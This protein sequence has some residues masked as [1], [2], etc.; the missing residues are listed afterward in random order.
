M[1]VKPRGG[2]GHRP[3][4]EGMD[5]KVRTPN[6]FHQPQTMPL[7][8]QE[9]IAAELPRKACYRGTLFTQ[10]LGPHITEINMHRA[11]RT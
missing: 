6:L 5:G 2:E 10:L 4:T 7:M 8:E 9:M 11:L 3:I 1:T